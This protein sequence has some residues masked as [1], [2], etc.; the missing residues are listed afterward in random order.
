M[1]F[2]VMLLFWFFVDDGVDDVDIHNGAGA[3]LHP[4]PSAVR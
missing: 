3:Q 2:G 4:W 1:H